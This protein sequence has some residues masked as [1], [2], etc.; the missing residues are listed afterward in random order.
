VLPRRKDSDTDPSTPEALRPAD[1]DPGLGPAPALPPPRGPSRPPL[2]PATAAAV[3]VAAQTGPKKDSVE[4]LLDGMPSVQPQQPRTTPQTAG[5]S[6]AAY[7]A[8]HAVR[9][10]HT[11]PDDMPKVVVERGPQHQTVRLDRARLQAVIEQ[12]QEVKARRQQE[13]LEPLEQDTGMPMSLRIAIAVVAGL[14]VVLG[15]FLFARASQ[16]STAPAPAAT[17]A[18]AAPPLASAASAPSAASAAPAMPAP[19]VSAA[20]TTPVPAPSDTQMSSTPPIAVS[21]AAPP[22]LSTGATPRPKPRSSAP[23]ATGGGTDL[24]EFKT[25]FH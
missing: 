4:L 20:A 18:R 5:Q 9:P 15:I 21:P 8:E 14:A 10:A 19:S 6:S 17:V 25:T 13:Q 3:S 2:P 23:A 7:H 22:P 24:G 12:A 11:S 1:T 16:S